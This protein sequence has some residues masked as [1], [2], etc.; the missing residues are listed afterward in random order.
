MHLV[1]RCKAA[2]KRFKFEGLTK[3]RF[4]AIS[5]WWT[6]TRSNPAKAQPR[7]KSS[8]FGW[9]HYQLHGLPHHKG[10]LLSFT[11]ENVQL[12]A[13]QKP[14][15]EHQQ[16]RKHPPFQQRQLSKPTVQNNPPS[17]AT[18]MESSTGAK[19]AHMI[20]QYSKCK[21][22]GHLEH[23]CDHICNHCS[24]FKHSKVGLTQ[25]G[26]VRQTPK[27]NSLWKWKSTLTAYGSKSTLTLRQKWHTWIEGLTVTFLSKGRAV[28]KC[29]DHTT[30]D[31]FYITPQRSLT[32][33]A[34]Q[35]C[36]V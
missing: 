8:A 25:T 30:E 32:Y 26:T 29:H 1:N 23:Q 18:T 14:P 22:T 3:E 31:V 5:N 36:S 4:D 7:W 17:P 28:F 2:L 10:W 34:I 21:H 13:V 24:K 20:H 33:S 35:P 12:N 9:H 15:Q 19:I 11:N 6:P 16:C 27:S